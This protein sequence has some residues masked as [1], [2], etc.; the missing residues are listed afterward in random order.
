MRLFKILKKPIQTEKASNLEMKNN[1]YVFIVAPDATK[2][3][4]KKAVLDIYGVMVA[5]VNILHTR[6]KFKYSK[7]KS[8]QLRKRSQKKAYVT[9]KDDK[10]KI[11]FTIVK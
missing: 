3:D 5:S 8:M 4:I 10:A 7:K 1:T 9:L 2:I 11:D 6:E